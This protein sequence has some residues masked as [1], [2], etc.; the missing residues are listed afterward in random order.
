MILASHLGSEFNAFLFAPI[1]E[2]RNGMLLSV[3]SV[4][5]RQNLDPWRE[6]ADLASLPHENAI[7]RLSSIIAAIPDEPSASQDASS[8]ATRLI[9]LLPRVPKFA[10]P[11]RTEVAFPRDSAHSKTII[12]IMIFMAVML[13]VQ[14]SWRI[15]PSRR[16]LER[17]VC[18]A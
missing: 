17:R 3:L 13:C 4:L 9:A 2:G 8:S 16:K 6:A 18:R 10:I 5:A 15:V 11:S 7:R 14:F 12:Y 1:G